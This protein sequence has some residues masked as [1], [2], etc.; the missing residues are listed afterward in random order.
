MSECDNCKIDFR[1]TVVGNLWILGEES[2]DEG[3]VTELYLKPFPKN[4]I[5]IAR[6]Y[7]N[8]T[9]RGAMTAILEELIKYCKNNNLNKIIIESVLT[10]EMVSFANKNGF[11]PDINS[12]YD[13]KGLL[14]G[15]YE[16]NL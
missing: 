8:N 9:R 15:N 5:T 12:I 11:K 13:Y 16:L 2:I 1:G 4:A 7:F 10:K 14:V 3:E 6:V